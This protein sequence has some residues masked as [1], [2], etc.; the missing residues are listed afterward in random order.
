MKSKISSILFSIVFT[1]FSVFNCFSQN[2]P[3]EILKN[4]YPIPELTKE[5]MYQDFDLF[6]DIIKELNPQ[7]PLY[8]NVAQYDMVDQILSL[9]GE[10]ENCDSTLQFIDVM[11]DCFRYCIDAHCFAGVY[12]WYY[13]HS[14]YA[15]MD[16]I[17]GL[18]EEDYG[19]LFHYRDQVF[20]NHPSYLITFPIDNE[21]YLKYQ[22]KFIAKDTVFEFPVGSKILNING[23][24]PKQVINSFKNPTSRYDLQKDIFYND[25]VLFESDTTTITIEYDNKQSTF[26]FH[27]TIELEK[28]INYRPTGKYIEKDSVLYLSLPMMHYDSTYLCKEIL[29]YSNV[30]IKSVIIDIRANRGGHDSTWIAILS[31]LSSDPFYYQSSLALR[32]H[33]IAKERYPMAKESIT[34]SLLGEEFKYLILE[35]IIDT[36]FPSKENLV[37]NG[38]VYLLVDQDIFS[39]AGAFNSLSKSNSRIVTIGTPT[40]S[41]VGRGITPD[42]FILPNS[43][44]I[45][46]MELALD[47]ANVTE[48]KDFFHDHVDIR[49]F[50]TI[51]YLKYYYHPKKNKEID[52]EEMYQNDIFF[53][54]AMEMIRSGK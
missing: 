44:L 51:D 17:L 19:I 34:F 24:P 12:V 54:K 26:S 18:N 2:N 5:Q 7:Y 50:P 33:P 6:V 35:N 27:K 41:Y 15:K 49:I 3:A 29:Q 21:Y 52:A 31:L 48:G 39:S 36:I 40:G 43:R 8:K 53:Q 4:K 10:I 37:Y 45:F 14:V 13:K 22:T 9:R 46:T 47:F 25:I 38:K 42:V 16:S 32:D 11:E 1:L 30:Y 23:L 28:E 20:H